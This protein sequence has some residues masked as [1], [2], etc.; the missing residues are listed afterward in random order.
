MVDDL[1]R[2]K[3]LFDSLE[4]PT[5]KY[6]LLVFLNK[7]KNES[8]YSDNLEKLVEYT[9]INNFNN[10]EIYELKSIKICIKNSKKN[11][12]TILKEKQ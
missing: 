12:K 4:E 5:F 2:K 1:M 3:E 9:T 10:Y 7:N 6:L 11:S 8:Y